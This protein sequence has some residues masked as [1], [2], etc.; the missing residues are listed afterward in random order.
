ADNWGQ[1]QELNGDSE[2]GNSL[3]ISGDTVVIGASAAN[4]FCGAAFIFNPSNCQAITVGPGS[5][6]GGTIGSPY[7]GVTFTQTGGI[8]SVTFTETGALP[9]GLTL[10]SDGVL[11]G[12][13]QQAGSFPI[14]V[15]ATDSNGCAGS[16]SYTVVINCP[17]ITV[18]PATIPA[19]A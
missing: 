4:N 12:T 13:P 8:G 1:A 5:I 3:G 11:S 16:S 2:F 17:A 9:T 18:S 6:P 15:T 19:G 14:T 10:S 7:E